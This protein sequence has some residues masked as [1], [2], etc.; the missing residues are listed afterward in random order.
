MIIK[1]VKVDSTP[2]KE[3]L[4]AKKLTLVITE[5]TEYVGLIGTLYSDDARAYISD[6]PAG[7]IPLEVHGLSK[8]DLLNKFAT[9]ISQKTLWVPGVPHY[10]IVPMLVPE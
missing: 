2:L 8:E 5:Y 4:T 9:K 6:E 7:K 3:F 10:I 1:H